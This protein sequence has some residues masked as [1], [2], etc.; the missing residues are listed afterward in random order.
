[1][2]SWLTWLAGVGSGTLP[3]AAGL[4]LCSGRNRPGPQPRWTRQI[5]S[6]AR[7]RARVSH[8][9]ILSEDARARAGLTL[10]APLKPAM[11]T[12]FFASGVLAEKVVC[13]P[14]DA[15]QVRARW[16]PKLAD[17]QLRYVM[18]CQPACSS[19]GPSLR[20]RV[21]ACLH[22]SPLGQQQPWQCLESAQGVHARSLPRVR[23]RA[24]RSSSR[25][26]RPVDAARAGAGV[27]GRALAGGHIHVAV[28]LLRKLVL[29]LPA[30]AH[31]RGCTLGSRAVRAGGGPLPA[32][33][34]V[35]APRPCSPR[36]RPACAGRPSG[37]ARRRNIFILHEMSWSY[38]Q[39]KL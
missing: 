27:P 5:H 1:M 13:L 25:G 23:R 12:D 17:T 14:L 31:P 16:Q 10:L 37:A 7:C 3:S 8:T 21:F 2:D 22:R 24:C 20:L 4:D 33:D 35:N 32:A 6:H 29:R 15:R 9:Q 26:C 34:A 30:G 39:D 36:K 11:L 18:Q 28:G 38:P 19:G